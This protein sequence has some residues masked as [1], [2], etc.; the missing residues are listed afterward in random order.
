MKKV[1]SKPEIMFEDFSLNNSITAGCNKIINNSAQTQCALL[2]EGI[3]NV[4]TTELATICTDFKVP[5]G[6]YDGI[7]YHVPVDTNDLFNS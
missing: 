5:D 6:G 4:F 1:Y 3:G 7:C 2:V